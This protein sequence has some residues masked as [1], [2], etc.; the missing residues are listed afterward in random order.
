[1]VG[2]CKGIRSRT[3]SEQPA[4]SRKKVFESQIRCEVSFGSGDSAVIF[5]ALAGEHQRLRLMHP[6]KTLDVKA[7]EIPFGGGDVGA[8]R[9]KVLDRQGRYFRRS[10][11]QVLQV[12]LG[13]R[14]FGGIDGLDDEFLEGVFRG[15]KRRGREKSRELGNQGGFGEVARP[16]AQ[17]SSVRHS[18]SRS[19]IIRVSEARGESWNAH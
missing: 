16:N 2:R 15:R 18:W 4:V 19:L 3:G 12:P 13:Q 5:G 17:I 8:V 11:S 7:P 9:M 1:M 6:F 14:K 10:I